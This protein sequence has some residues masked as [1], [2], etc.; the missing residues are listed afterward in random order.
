VVER[1]GPSRAGRAQRTKGAELPEMTV[2]GDIESNALFFSPTAVNL[3]T[4]DRFQVSLSYFNRSR[5]DADRINVWLHYDPEL[6]EPVWVDT[7][8]L[9]A[10]TPTLPAV[11]VWRKEGYVHLT[12]PVSQPFEGGIIPLM[13]TYWRTLAPTLGTKISI[14]TP[15]EQEESGVF[16]GDENLI[17]TSTLDSLFGVS[18]IV[19]VAPD[20]EDSYQMNEVDELREAMT[21]EPD[22]SVD[23]LRLALVTPG[24]YIE[25]GEVGVADVVL[26]NPSELPFD[27]LRFRIRYQ[28]EM[29]K[30]L[31][32]DADNYITSGINI[33]DGDFHPYFPFDFHGANEVD[34]ERGVI[35][36]HMGAVGGSFAFPSGTV[37]RIVYRMLRDAGKVSF[38]FEI[39][40]PLTGRRVTDVSA[41]G[42]SLL[43]SDVDAQKALHGVQVS[44]QPMPKT[45]MT[46]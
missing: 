6:L 26:I 45:A 20:V 11:K 17:Y 4:G 21:A 15:A 38:W 14:R 22:D 37:A 10:L 16:A 3:V 25:S 24:P 2:P 13:T 34:P 32:A 39:S 1:R 23:R 31:D 30:I 43:G 12:T 19:R 7:E 29:V 9:L 8:P 42:L 40:D 36:Y 46:R 35:T 5:D 41:D 33:F 18:M 27:Q 44:V 28:P